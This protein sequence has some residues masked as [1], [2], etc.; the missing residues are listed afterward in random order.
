MPPQISDVFLA[1]VEVAIRRLTETYSI[2]AQFSTIVNTFFG[3]FGD[4]VEGF[5]KV[6]ALSR[7][8]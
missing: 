3:E 4:F 7:F 8:L 1:F 5:S 2:V 6:I